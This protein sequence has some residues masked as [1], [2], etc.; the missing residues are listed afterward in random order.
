MTS[1]RCSRLS[2][3]FVNLS[4]SRYQAMIWIIKKTVRL[5]S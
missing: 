4:K 2:T 1:G 3:G 5:N